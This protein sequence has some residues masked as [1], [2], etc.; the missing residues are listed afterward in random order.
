MKMR[1]EKTNGIVYVWLNY[2]ERK[3]CPNARDLYAHIMDLIKADAHCFVK[4]AK[5]ER[6]FND[7]GEGQ[8]WVI[9]V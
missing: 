3:A 7:I 4:Y 8:V 5:V 9:D 1:V 6:M 2:E